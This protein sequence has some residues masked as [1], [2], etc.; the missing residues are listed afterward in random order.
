MA[1]NKEEKKKKTKCTCEEECTCG[2]E[3]NCG[4]NCNC[5]EE[6]NCNHEETNDLNKELEDKYLR[7]QAEFVNFRNR[8][9][10]E[11]SNLLKYENEDVI[12]KL[13]PTIDNFERAIKMD[14]NDL[15]DEVSKFL[16]GFKMIYTSLINVLDE[17]EVKEI[18]VLGK[19]FDPVYAE[20]VLVE[21]DENKPENVV[22]EVLT[23]GYMYKDK[24]IRPAMVKV[25]K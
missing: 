8:Q 4:E 23:K 9:M 1:K 18:E 5:T 25:N 17:L 19:E 15:A 21:H 13:L 2:N 12:K 6:C 7:L 10:N 14:N 11:I 16:E 24:V 22:L 3:C 20:A